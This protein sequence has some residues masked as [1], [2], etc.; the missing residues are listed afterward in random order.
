VRVERFR[1]KVHTEQRPTEVYA[2]VL[3]NRDGKLGPGLHP[4]NNECAERA[5]AKKEF[6]PPR[7]PDPGQR[8]E[9]GITSRM[10]GG[11]RQLRLGS[12]RI[13]TLLSQTNAR[14]VLGRLVVD[15]TGL[16]GPFDIALDYVP[17]TTVSA[18]A[19]QS[20]QVGAAPQPG[21]PSLLTALR[22]Q[23][24]LR[25]EKRQEPVDVLVIDHVEMPTPN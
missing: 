17:E 10:N 2:L 5:A 11:V 20:E 25:F 16:Q 23:L 15:R 13:S 22:E 4:A 18:S 19:G 14:S 6:P 7:F 24:G 1:L 12:M 3:A 8:H 9:C 21:G